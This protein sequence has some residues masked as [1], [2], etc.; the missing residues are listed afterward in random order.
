MA[1]IK[2]C[3]L[4]QQRGFSLI[5]LMITIPL[6]LLV[7]FAVLKIFTVSMQGVNL[8][9][10]FSRVQENGRMA[11]E[12]L[13]RDIR[14]ADYWGCLRDTSLIINHL[15]DDD[16]DFDATL[17]PTGRMGVAGEDNV[18]SQTIA[19]I[20]VKDATDTLTLR[21][22]SSIANIKIAY[23]YVNHNAASIHINPGG[24]IP[25]GAS[26]MIGDCAGAD[27]VTVSSSN[28]NNGTIV[29]NSGNLTINLAVDN[30]FKTLSRTYSSSAQLMTPYVKTYFIGENAAG[31]YS[32]FLTVDNGVA[33]ELVRGVNDL[34]LLYGEDTNDNGAPDTFSDASGGVNMNTVR[35]IRFSLVAQSSSGAGNTPLSKTYTVTANIRNRTL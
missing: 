4:I 13:I 29:H 30:E 11:T 35:S 32:L 8:Q 7:M 33:N 5:E 28:S 31:S 26:I 6:G 20:P 16:S 15:D 10:A 34:Q 21:G 22:A 19:S 17:I 18:S 24:D 12:L 9:N 25:E 3:R 2:N 23:P 1:T 14:G 27:L